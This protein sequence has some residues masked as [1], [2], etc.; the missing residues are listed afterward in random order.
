MARL[1]RRLDHGDRVT[2]VEHL[3]ELRTRLIIALVAVGMGFAL[4]FAF[5][6]HGPDLAPGAAP[7]RPAA[8][9]LRGHRAVLH[10]RQGELL[11]RSRARAADRPLAD[12]ELPCSGRRG[13]FAAHRRR[14]RRRR[15]GALRRRP[16]VRVLGRFPRALDFLVALQRG[17]LRHRDP[18]ELLLLVR[19]AR[20]PRDRPRLRAAI[21]VLA[22]VRLGVVTRTG[23]AKTAASG[24]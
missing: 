5:Q 9:D 8:H 6:D 15:H 4:A 17:V 20:H 22:L 18:G 23:Y 2:L 14:L 10:L 11:R 7:G 3:D 19:L 12:L 24:T 21:F 16:R 13:A 1:P